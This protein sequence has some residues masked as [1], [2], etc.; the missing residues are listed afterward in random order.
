M[1]QK[2]TFLSCVVA[3]LLFLAASGSHRA[4]AA[5]TAA[6][7]QHPAVPKTYDLN[8]ITC[9]DLLRAN[10]IDRSS[11]IMFLWGFEAGRRNV[12]SFA[13][14]D[15]EDA[16]RRLMANCEAKPS[17]SLFAALEATRKKNAQ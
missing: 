8:K 13:T 17:L 9:S 7:A 1:R 16:T 3:A 12:T 2:A 11:A 4:L 6:P 10:I 14:A 15:L 5:S